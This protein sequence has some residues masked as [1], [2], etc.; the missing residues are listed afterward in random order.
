[1]NLICNAD[2]TLLNIKGEVLRVTKVECNSF[3]MYERENCRTPP[4][5]I[6][7]F[8]S[9]GNCKLMLIYLSFLYYHNKH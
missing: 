8:W 5:S 9:D 4:L 6:D 7:R 2:V 1:M 3:S